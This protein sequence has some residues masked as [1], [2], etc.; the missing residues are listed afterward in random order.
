MAKKHKKIQRP[1]APP[2]SRTDKAI[3][4]GLYLLLIASIPLLILLVNLIR[5]KIAYQDVETIAFRGR[6]SY[7]WVI[8]FFL[9]LFLG[10]MFPLTVANEER[11][12]ILGNKTICYGERP[13]KSD[14][15]P[16]F[17]PQHKKVDLPQYAKRMRRIFRFLWFAGI[18]LIVLTMAF[19]LCRRNTLRSDQTIAV[20]DTYNRQTDV[21][22]IPDDCTALTIQAERYTSGKVKLPRWCYRITLFTEDGSNYDF[23]SD[24]FREDYAEILKTMLQIKAS[25]SSEDITIKGIDTLEDM[26]DFYELK[27]EEIVLLRELFG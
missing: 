21:I 16:M 17:G 24:D 12:P 9:H 15:Y 11:R 4:A 8:P 13:W 20:Y 5:E 2:L 18:F 10:C 26:I 3:Y 25:F 23:T 27:N 6:L 7:L 1:E 19:C 22:S 14:L